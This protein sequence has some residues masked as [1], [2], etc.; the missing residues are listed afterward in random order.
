MSSRPFAAIMPE[1]SVVVVNYNTREPL[2]RC[3]QSL[4][5]E[6]DHVDL[7]VIVVDNGS[8]DGSVDMVRADFPDVQLIVPGRNTWFTGGNNLGLAAAQGEYVLI[9][10]PDT[11]VFSGT[12][13]TMLAYLREHPRVGAVACRQVFPDGETIQN[14][15]RAPR[16][17]DLL[18]GYTF[19]GTLLAPWRARRRAR[20]WYDGWDRL[21][22]RAVEVIPDSCLM[23]SRALL[24]RLG[25]FD[26][27]FKLYFTEDDLC[28][29]IRETGHEIHFLAEA[30][31]EHQEHASVSQVQRLASQ[32]YFDDL[33]VYA[34]KYYGRAAAWGLRVLVAPTR[35]AMDVMQRLRGERE[36][37]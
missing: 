21:S 32:I 29:R 16:Y 17:V 34:R 36:A 31:I 24:Q 37:L 33:I 7:E 26:E 14:A 25:G 1:L 10:N 8:R 12:L 22:T 30:A 27:A 15:S 18:L 19:L 11:V 35:R 2:R 6:R 5:A 23:A 28:I 20:M 13:Q 9:L 4:H 3:L